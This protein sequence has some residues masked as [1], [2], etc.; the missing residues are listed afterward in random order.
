MVMKTMNLT[1]AILSLGA[2][3]ILFS[4]NAQNNIVIE[5]EADLHVNDEKHPCLSE[6]EYQIIEADIIRNR[7]ALGLELNTSKSNMQTSLQWPMKPSANATDCGYY[8]VSAFVDMNNT[9]GQIQDWNCGSRTYDGHRGIDIVPWPF[10]WNKMDSNLAEVIAAAPGTIISKVDGNPD[11]VC[12]GVGGGSNSNNYITIQH[13]DGSTALYIHMKTGSLTTKSVGQTVVAGEY[14]GI[15]GS[16]GQSTGVHLHFEIRSNGTFASYIDPFY[17]TCNTSIGSSWWANQKP[18]FEPELMKSSIHQSWPYMAT[19]PVTKDTL[20]EKYSFVSNA[21]QQ[22]VFYACT[23]HVL[24]G[25]V[26]NFKIFDSGNNVFDSWNFTSNQNRNTSTLGFFKNLPT[27]P[28]VYKFQTVFLND[29]CSVFFNITSGST[30]MAEIS[31]GESISLF[32]N[33]NNGNFNVIVNN[34]DFLANQSKMII[35]NSIGQIIHELNLSTTK[36]EL[37]L[38]VQ[39]GVYFY[40]ISE[41]NH[42]ESWGKFIIE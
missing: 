19:C 14:L 35:Y 27:T 20:Y 6:E 4:T 42:K 3:F 8:Y 1:K 18:Y 24:T 36:N 10:I 30:A 23:K 38:D 32:P 21:G 33:P 15:P 37:Y 7:K 9:A 13:A 29:T 12:N 41:L 16:A 25:D 5:R 39:P 2:C 22:A 40:K 28:G 26:W 17:G 31:K 34:K 11:R